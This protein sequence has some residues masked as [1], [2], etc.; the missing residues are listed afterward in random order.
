MFTV[1][2]SNQIDVLKSL[3][4]QL[5]KLDPLQNPFEKEQILV[6]SPGMSQWLKMALAQEFGIAANIDFP[7]PAT[8]IWDRFVQVL[9]DVPKRSAFNKE[10][11]TWKIMHL[12][13]KH[14]DDPDFAPLAQYLSD[15]S[16][17]SKR[18]QL[19]EKI[20]DIYDGYLVYRPEW[21]ATWEAGQSVVELEGEQ[22]WQPKLWQALY[23]HTVALEQSPYHRA[24]LYEHFIDELESNKDVKTHGLSQLPKRLFVFGISSLPPRYLDAL[25]ALGE[26]IDVHL[27]FTNPCRFYWGEVRD[28][29][30]LAR[31]AAAKRKQLSDLDSFVSSQDWQEGDWAFAQQLKGDIEANVDD[32]L[33][34]SEVG[35]SLL[36][37]MGKLGRDNLY[38]LSQL[39]SNEIEAFVEVERNTLLQNI[40]A[41]ILNLDEHQDDTLL[42]S[43]EHKPCIEA[44]DNSL[45]VHVCHSPMREVEVLH[46]N[47]L[48]MFDQNPELKP[49]DIIVMV[50]DI[51]AYSPAI[52]AVFGNASG[53][54]YIPFSI[55][56]R[57]ADK[58][59]PLLNAFN[60]LLQLPELRCTSSEV[61]ELLEVPAI[62]ARFDI[63]EHE[64]ST[65]RAWVEEAQI[66][67]GIDAHTASEFDLPE[68]GQN[69]WM[70]GISR[71]LAG[72]A[73]SE[74]AGLLM[75]GGE[76][77]SPYEQT[78][79]MQAETAGKLAQFIDKLA[80][81]RGA[82][83]Q[84]MS[85]SSWQQ[86]INQ[87]VDDFFAV[88]IEGEVV[89][90]SIRDT[91]SGLSEQLADARYDE[92]LSPRIIRQYF[93][94]K[95]SGSRV[96]QRFL[97]GQV[98]F[99]TLMPMRSI[100]FNTVCLLGMNDGVY[101][102]SVPPESFDLMTGRTKPGDRSRRDDDRYL[103]LE[104][105]LSAQ[106][107]LYISYV[108]RSIQDNTERVPSVLVSELLEYCE[109]NYCLV[110]DEALDVDTSGAKL[111][112]SL[113]HEYPMVPFSAAHFDS[114]Y[115]IQ[116]Y[117]AEWLPSAWQTTQVA[118][119]QT[120]APF[121]LDP[122]DRV[123]G[124]R[125]ELD[126]SELHRFWRLPVQYLFNRRLQVNFDESLLGIEDEEPFALNG[127]ESFGLR[128]SLLDVLIEPEDQANKLA[129]FK[130]QQK[131][132]GYL[133]VNQ[134]GELEFAS[135]VAQTQDLAEAIVPLTANELDGIEID[136]SIPLKKV[137]VTLQGWVTNCY[138]SGLVRYRSGRLR[139]SD[140]LA[141]WIDHL[142]VSV[143]GHQTRT[144][145]LAYDKKEGVVH[146]IYPVMSADEAM[147]YL[148]QLVSL[149]V[150][151][152][153]S[154]L[155]YFP[156]TALAGIEAN[157]SRG[158]WSPNDDKMISK[159]QARFVGGYMQ[160]GEGEN[161]YISRVWSEWSDALANDAKQLAHLVL[162]AP[163]TKSVSAE[164][165][166]SQST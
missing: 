79:G 128:K 84:T 33:H 147:N 127:L 153:D 39:E 60:Q 100:P 68:F 59:S 99:C 83:T 93:L 148:T 15:D 88:D 29:K 160:T 45:S 78:Q 115:G 90:K 57:T 66:R 17:A 51:N 49:R 35:N 108:G 2:H 10:A 44:S 72:Y 53:E 48:A 67:W 32:E 110:G 123:E 61:L 137:S 101:P 126:L 19:A 89:V 165:Y 71:M 70:F 65:L 111:T 145:M 54:R 151:G 142:L 38:L 150:D 129:H 37:S 106:Q 162:E 131:A 69:S 27:M 107:T 55:S 80:H 117:A 94:D 30:Y 144:H 74:Q 96:S 7:L 36:A 112:K 139:A 98:N 121:H 132:Q 161:A 119:Q 14:L 154:P 114:T 134:F 18:Y 11:M 86:H 9:D 75:V 64:F 16:D 140:Y 95:L 158:Q 21:I 6:Q 122:I 25:K 24:N 56:D 109:Q 76:G 138:Q 41:D 4:V 104:A 77:I 3:L 143:S 163:R 103:F 81:Y 20:A 125:I 40:Q 136:I 28:R 62:M 85:I 156:E 13:P 149:F 58:E 87:L 23:D 166:Y 133:P 120:S 113:C 91:L 63:N 118:A 46:D 22:P 47:L 43:S 141:A 82:L 164:E 42:L 105:M 157:Y 135:N 116:S 31:L 26:H 92:S 124:E 52:Q 146:R 8:F 50:A 97:A 1:Y 34:L 12:L 5:I 152:L 155:S 159:M 73:I 130:A 102:R